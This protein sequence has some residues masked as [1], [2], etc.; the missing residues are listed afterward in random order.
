M[1]VALLMLLCGVAT[2]W[3]PVELVQVAKLD[4]DSTSSCC[5]FGARDGEMKP[6]ASPE[7]G[8]AEDGP[9]VGVLALVC[10]LIQNEV[11]VSTI[12]TGSCPRPFF[13]TP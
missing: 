9:N 12:L 4:S 8:V 3:F 6:L 5:R 13:T 2:S 1:G 7:T 11:Y 10:S